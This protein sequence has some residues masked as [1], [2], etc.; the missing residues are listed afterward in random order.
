MSALHEEYV[1][2]PRRVD[3]REAIILL[4][5]AV[6]KH[7][8]DY[9]CPG[10]KAMYFDG[11]GRPYCLIGVALASVGLKRAHLGA[12]NIS[13]VDGPGFLSKLIQEADIILS[14]GAIAVFRTAQAAQ[15][16]SASWGEALEEAYGT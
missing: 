2:N 1:R 4:Q 14:E 11:V 8:Y 7:G 12:F 15:D 13:R 6:L 10:D 16:D 5:R 3:K 9:C